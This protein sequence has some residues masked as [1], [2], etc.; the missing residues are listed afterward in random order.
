MSIPAYMDQARRSQRRTLHLQLQ[1]IKA[2]GDRMPVLVHNISA[3]GL[4]IESETPLAIGEAIDI[5]LPHAGKTQAKV[6]WSSERIYGCQFDTTVSAAALS[7]AQLRSVVGPDAQGAA[8]PSPPPTIRSFGERL[9]NLRLANGL[10]QAQLAAGLGVSEPSVS[11]WEQGRSRPKA[12]RME[13]LAELLGVEMVELL[14]I[15]ERPDLNVAV[16]DAR[17]KI[18]EAAGISLDQI[19]I[20][21]EM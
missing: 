6:I 9:H 4:L 17:R 16:A 14:G 15:C 13:A 7:A 12:G 19:R 20:R 21:I 10:T 2:T 11:A 18:A 1:S 3:T 5:D 8:P